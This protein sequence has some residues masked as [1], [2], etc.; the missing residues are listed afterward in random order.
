LIPA[1]ARQVCPH[2]RDTYA[3]GLKEGVRNPI[4]LVSGRGTGGATPNREL[5]AMALESR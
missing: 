2:C 4:A 1:G 5:R 3:Q